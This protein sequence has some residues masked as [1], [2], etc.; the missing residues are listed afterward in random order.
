MKIRV[1]KNG[2]FVE[3]TENTKCYVGR[4]SSGHTVFGES[5]KLYKVLANHLV[6]ITKSGSLVKNK[7]EYEY[8]W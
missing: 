1:F 2:E 3:I 4:C 7:H 5:A 6:F 8:C